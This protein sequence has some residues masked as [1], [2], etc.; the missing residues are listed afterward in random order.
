MRRRQIAAHGLLHRL[1]ARSVDGGEDGVPQAHR[2]LDVPAIH[3]IGDSLIYFVDRWD[4]PL[5]DHWFPKVDAPD[6]VPS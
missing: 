3:G 4:Q 6:L 5:L 2:T 1:H